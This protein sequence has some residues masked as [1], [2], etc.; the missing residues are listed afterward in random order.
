[1]ISM[2]RG[3][4]HKVS[5]I[6]RQ[7]PFP[8]PS[9][10]LSA[11]RQALE[12][13]NDAIRVCCGSRPGFSTPC[14]TRQDTCVSGSH[15]VSPAHLRAMEGARE[16]L[17]TDIGR[18]GRGESDGHVKADYMDED[19]RED[20]ED[21]EDRSKQGGEARQAVGE[22]G[23]RDGSA[24]M[25][26]SSEKV[27]VRGQSLDGHEPKHEPKL[28]SA[29]PAD[30]EDQMDR[31]ER[32]KRKL[33]EAS[34]MEARKG[35]VKVK[36]KE[37]LVVAAAASGGVERMTVDAAGTSD[38]MELDQK[39]PE[40]LDDHKGASSE[41]EKTEKGGSDAV[42]ELPTSAE[43]GDVKMEVNEDEQ[44]DLVKVEAPPTPPV[45]S[46]E[47]NFGKPVSDS[48]V[49]GKDHVEQ[50][51]ATGDPT[52]DKRIKKA[53]LEAKLKKLTAEKHRLVQMLK[54]VLS[55][56]EESKKKVQSASQSPPAP[57]A[58]PASQAA[59]IS[60][61]VPAA[62]VVQAEGASAA[63]SE[64]Q[65][66][67][68]LEEGELEYAR[69]PSP[70]SH[71]TSTSHAPSHG[72]HSSHG[73]APALGPLL[74]R[75]PQ[76]MNQ[77]GSARGNYYQQGLS[78]PSPSSAAAAAALA[79]AISPGTGF[80]PLALGG[81]P[82]YQHQMVMQHA[83]ALHAQKVAAVAAAAAAGHSHMSPI[84]GGGGPA[85]AGAGVNNGPPGF[86]GY[87]VSPSVHGHH[88]HM[89]QGASPGAGH[90]AAQQGV[91]S[92]S[93]LTTPRGAPGYHDLRN[94]NPPWNLQR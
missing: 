48:K 84:L 36:V 54:Q 3:E 18:E 81:R 40:G 50:A 33:E 77:G 11:F 15:N 45:H 53:E 61:D 37:E 46:E 64:V 89:S 31:K 49:E 23:Y 28:E 73:S 71:T 47:Q 91:A 32:K 39:V 75:Q 62:P 14:L 94:L 58:Q 4:L 93:L 24:P 67:A 60:A 21:A 17:E 57:G 63:A 72:T 16:E 59:P 29:E 56:E 92:P 52:G 90:I 5:G 68:D 13:R 34:L 51:K 78:L 79:G 86:G 22:E 55:T 42:P 88:G 70:P 38:E 80:M 82:N 76:H 27:L 83:A 10:T 30:L 26:D 35:K 20:A 1:M 87:G 65:P 66:S 44:G 12:K 6:T 8:K 43:E 9:I 69:T 74:G 25:E 19:V 2:Y 85:G 41:V 7:W